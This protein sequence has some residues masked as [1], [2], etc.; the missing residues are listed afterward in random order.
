MRDLLQRYLDH[1]LS[2]REFTAGLTAL[3]LS[4]GAAEAVAADADATAGLPREGIKVEGTPEI[5]VPTMIARKEAVTIGAAQKPG[6]N[7]EALKKA[8]GDAEDVH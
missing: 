8:M 2:R 5:D 1:E 3:G 7:F 4:A 6:F